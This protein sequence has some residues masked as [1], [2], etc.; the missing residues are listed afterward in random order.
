MKRMKKILTLTAGLAMLFSLFLATGTLQLTSSAESTK[1]WVDFEPQ[2]LTE[3]SSY[4]SSFGEWGAQAETGL[5]LNYLAVGPQIQR[6]HTNGYAAIRRFDSTIS[7]NFYLEQ[8][9]GNAVISVTGGSNGDSIKFGIFN[10]KYEMVWPTTGDWFTA[11]K[12]ETFDGYIEA[13]I[14]AGGSL[15][16]I[17][18]SPSSPSLSL[19]LYGIGHISSKPKET[20][21]YYGKQI[22]SSAYLC[23]G[24]MSTQGVAGTHDVGKW[25]Y[26]YAPSVELTT[27]DPNA[28]A[29]EGKGEYTVDYNDTLVPMH[30]I[31]ADNKDPNT[32]WLGDGAYNQTVFASGL[33]V[34]FGGL[35]HTFVVRY[36]PSGPGDF[37]IGY[38]GVELRN[39][40]TAG[41]GI[42]FCI[43]D[44]NG[45]VVYPESGGPVELRADSDDPYAMSTAMGYYQS[46]MQVGEYLDFVFI[47]RGAL[48]ANY[49]KYVYM[50]GSFNHPSAT[51]S[52]NRIDSSGRL[53][54]ANSEEQGSRNIQMFTASNVT[55]NKV[56]DGA[57]EEFVQLDSALSAAPAT[58]EGWVN[59]P[60]AVP[61]WKT[62]TILSDMSGADENGLSVMMDTFG[63]PRFVSGNV[64]WTVESVDLRTGEWQHVA[65]TVDTANATATFYQN[66]VAVATTALAAD[67]ALAVTDRAAVI[68]NNPRYASTTAYHGA[69][70]KLALY[71]DV[72][73]ADEIAADM[74]A[75]SASADNL[76]GYWVLNGVYTDKSS[77]K[78][79]GKLTTVNSIW[80]EDGSL[81]DAEE[82]EYTII[83]V[84]D[85]Q[86]I[87]D[88]Y[89]GGYQKITEWI[90]ANAERLNVQMVINSGDLV[91]YAN[92]E[93]GKTTNDQWKDAVA[94]MNILKNA[95]IPYVYAPGNHEYASSGT[96]V[97][98]TSYEFN[99]HFKIEEHLVQGT[100]QANE[101]K[102]IYAYPGTQRIDSEADLTLL[103]NNTTGVTVYGDTYVEGMESAF[104]LATLG[105]KQYIILALEVQPRFAVTEWASAI[106]KQLEDEF[107]EAGTEVTTI[108]VTHDYLSNYGHLE[109]AFNSCFDAADRKISHTAASLYSD[110]ISQFESIQ[111]VLCGH[112]ATGIATRTDIGV[113]GNKITTIMNDQS[114]EGNGGEGNILLL[115]Y[116]ADGTMVKAE[117]YSPI[118]EKYYVPQYQFDFDTSAEDELVLNMA[119]MKQMT[120]ARND[121]VWFISSND[122]GAARPY[123]TH[124][125]WS[126]VGDYVAVKAYEAQHS[127]T[128]TFELAVM[129]QQNDLQMM[130]CKEDGTILWPSTGIWTTPKPSSTR[131]ITCEIEAGEKVFVCAR[132][133]DTS[134]TSRQP[135]YGEIRSGKIVANGETLETFAL[136]YNTATMGTTAGTGGWYAYYANVSQLTL[137]PRTNTVTYGVDGEGGTLS[138]STGGTKYDTY[139]AVPTGGTVRFTAKPA[140][141][142]RIVGYYVDGAYYKS[143]KRILCMPMI[144]RDMD[145]KVV[146]EKI[147]LEGDANGDGIV[148][149]L[150]AVFL[151]VNVASETPFENAP[152]C[153]LE[154]EIPAALGVDVLDDNDVKALRKKILKK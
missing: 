6:V 30:K 78:N 56:V 129:T 124:N 130:V 28:C 23:G 144:E 66:G 79:N 35:N 14:T 11:V 72:R 128:M 69:M 93:A 116:R 89:R 86:V 38:A 110:F 91:N 150:D 2:L 63:H 108:V 54:L 17:A 97:P 57:W 127:G 119:S 132:H 113:K 8:Y 145:V 99:D 94:G 68:G 47:P 75:V 148:D 24:K 21:G 115:R 76:I 126:T 53:F 70:K 84:G 67:A 81:A 143:T 20:L 95:G 92:Y 103:E 32:A 51:A 61:D 27:A 136:G 26:M 34:Y 74:T 80:Y 73:T 133:P 3:Y 153:D 42:D 146:F 120:Y 104:Y 22:H 4:G 105:G 18:V 140:V 19:N 64:D 117:Y 71:A 118:L 44:Q 151:K 102:L 123:V 15:Y 114:Y 52:G 137:V 33:G 112:V 31:S 9:S 147:P 134:T 46:N 154:D 55:V 45:K 107:A 122:Q 16:F 40:W 100:G 83:H 90:A 1:T 125:T 25:Y 131:T 65:F 138:A 50:A 98:R 7:G 109:S 121:A 29:D 41:T 142:Y 152:L 49:A 139:C 36:T 106:L 77:A 82:G 62:G 135:V 85:N 48:A 111:L 60:T 141:G 149:V 13:P 37:K 12:G 5:S 39:S 59:I 43:V 88:F 10:E 58:V 96:S 101:T 87:T